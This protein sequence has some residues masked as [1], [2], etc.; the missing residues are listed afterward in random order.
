MKINPNL[1][2]RPTFHRGLLKISK[3]KDSPAQVV[4]INPNGR[5]KKTGKVD[6]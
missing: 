2:Y 3:K 1:N 4:K 6:L 5:E